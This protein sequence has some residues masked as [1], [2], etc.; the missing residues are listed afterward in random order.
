MSPSKGIGGI[1]DQIVGTGAV[2][3]SRQSKPLPPDNHSLQT[4]REPGCGEIAKQSKRMQARRGRPLGKVQ[5]SGPLEPEPKAKVT[6]WISQTLID[7]Y[8]DWSWEARHPLSTLVQQA[9][10]DYRNRCRAP[11]RA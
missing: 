6:V 10:E 11:S 7:Q 8:R 2:Q 5:P 4:E 3:P 1:L 9:M